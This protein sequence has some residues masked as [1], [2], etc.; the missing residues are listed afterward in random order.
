MGKKSWGHWIIMMHI[1]GRDLQ[2]GICLPGTEHWLRIVMDETFRPTLLHSMP[3]CPI[4]QIVTPKLSGLKIMSLWS[5]SSRLSVLVLPQTSYQALISKSLLG[6]ELLWKHI[7]LSL[8][9]MQTD[10]G[11][12]AGHASWAPSPWPLPHPGLPHSMVARFQERERASYKSQVEKVWLLWLAWELSPLPS[13]T[14]GN[15]DS[16]GRYRN[17]IIARWEQPVH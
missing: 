16:R 9:S 11:A 10:I 15:P 2:L 1:F 8:G 6:L 7:L 17:P 4:I 3:D 5:Q 13:W 14:L 12:S